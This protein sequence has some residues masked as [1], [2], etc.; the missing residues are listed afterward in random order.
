LITPADGLPAVFRIA[1]LISSLV[2]Q[3]LT[4]K[5]YAALWVDW[6]VPFSVIKGRITIWWAS[7]FGP[8]DFVRLLCIEVF[9]AIYPNIKIDKS[10]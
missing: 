6:C 8:P 2:D 4:S 7:S 3:G 1:A 10:S 5:G 9:I